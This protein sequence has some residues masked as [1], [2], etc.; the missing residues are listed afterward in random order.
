M[1]R[2]PL[3]ARVDDHLPAAHAVAAALAQ[4][5]VRARLHPLPRTPC[6]SFRL[7][8]DAHTLLCHVEAAGW[9]A[10]HLP[11][12]DGLDWQGM[13]STVV[14]GLTSPGRPLAFAESALSYDQAEPLGRVAGPTGTLP[15]VRAEEGRVWIQELHAHR[16]VAAHHTALCADLAVPLAL[17]LGSVD[18]PGARLRRL[19]RGDIVLLTRTHVRATHAGR[20]LFDYLLHEESITV[21]Q[22]EHPDTVSLAPAEADAFTP[23]LDVGSLPLCLQVQL[24]ELPLSVAELSALQP[25]SVLPLPPRAYQQ[26]ALLH[27][28]RRIARGELVQVGD[29]LG[30]RLTQTAALS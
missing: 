3:L 19:A 12:L 25:G 17:L 26:V 8:G 18:L 16:A 10:V 11:G 29:E 5:G 27:G 30:V 28:Q 6:L 22:F 14:A 24:C 13:D 15:A 2:F 9:A 23:P 4:R 1:N 7:T 21:N 20:P